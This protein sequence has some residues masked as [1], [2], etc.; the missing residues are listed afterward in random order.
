MPTK[1]L[2][3]PAAG[4][5]ERLSYQQQ[6]PF[7]TRKCLN[8][9]PEE[10]IGGRD[11]GG[12]RPGLA[13]DYTYT[14]FTGT[15]DGSAAKDNGTSTITP[16]ADVFDATVVGGTFT[17]D[18]SGTG[19]P[20]TAYNDVGPPAT[21][22]VTGDATVATGGETVDD[23][24]VVT[25]GGKPIAMG[26]GNP[27]NM[28]A[29]VR[30]VGSAGPGKLIQ[31]DFS[32]GAGATPDT[33]YWTSYDTSGWGTLYDGNLDV[34][35]ANNWLRNSDTDPDTGGH[36]GLV[37]VAS[38]GAG[39]FV[40]TSDINWA[41]PVQISFFVP[42][43]DATYG[44]LN[45]RIWKVHLFMDVTTPEQDADEVEVA[46]LC[47]PTSASNVGGRTRLDLRVQKT[48]GGAVTTL[49]EIQTASISEGHEPT[50][51]VK[52]RRAG[53][54]SSG[55][56]TFTIAVAVD[57]QNR[58]TTT[59]HAI[60]VSTY[61]RIGVSMQEN[62]QDTEVFPVPLMRDFS[63]QYSSRAH[64]VLPPEVIVAAAN[65]TVYRESLNLGNVDPIVNDNANGIEYDQTISTRQRLGKLYIADYDLIT[66]QTG[67]G[68]PVTID[69]DTGI[70]THANITTLYPT[71]GYTTLGV[72][73]VDRLE[74]T[75]ADNANAI[76]VW[77]ITSKTD[78]TITLTD[79][80]DL[81]D[82]DDEIASVKYRILCGPKVYDPSTD[83]LSAWHN[84]TN[85]V[86][87]AG[88][89]LELTGH[90]IPI[91]AKIVTSYKD[92]MILA[93]DGT[94]AVYMSRA[95]DPDDWDF[96]VSD[97]DEDRA[98]GLGAATSEIAGLPE[99]VTAVI[100]HGDDY[101]LISSKNTFWVLRGD[102]GSGGVLDNLS[103]D[104]GC[105]SRF[106]HCKDPQG[107]AFF[108]TNNGIY[109]QPPGATVYP[110]KLSKVAIPQ[111]LLTVDLEVIEPFLVYS[112]RYDGVF[113]YLAPK[114]KRPM[115]AWFFDSE[116]AGFFPVQYPDQ[117]HHPRSVLSYKPA[118]LAFT[119]TLLGGKDGFIRSLGGITDD[120]TAIS[121]ECVIG[122]IRMGL[123]GGFV[124]ELRAVLAEGSGDVDWALST[125]D[126]AE[127][128][129]GNTPPA[130]GT[131]EAG[132][133]TIDRPKVVG[134]SAYLHM[135]SVNQWGMESVEMKADAAPGH[136]PL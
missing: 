85:T 130:S 5:I 13:K 114:D 35:E 93:A 133:N 30:K 56:A 115:E 113:I 9:L 1:T 61:H 127:Q 131:W 21:I 23:T 121:S 6:P 73:A 97:T 76:G 79:W 124:N 43:N 54:D 41:E 25:G 95:G 47:F 123:Q 18:D 122:P 46:F 90:T 16:T 135:S 111:S 31:D 129:M 65:G 119:K 134:R 80:I 104:V 63:L 96:S 4:L 101:L 58:L 125:G 19:Y 91:A 27:V 82:G 10:N 107:G 89:P 3:F 7:S 103:H 33:D 36:K 92:R 68:D 106:A 128:A 44:A 64:A 48:V 49:K 69:D 29:S 98:I 94:G 71:N 2:I 84:T 66:D 126:A 59:T 42:D 53:V 112:L 28:L 109:Y 87:D 62:D 132:H 67:T 50:F 110:Q 55:N 40:G 100:P 15:V 102:P 39:D 105:I 51:G 11:R 72:T 118:T 57:G 74:I 78:T 52:V 86:I 45:Y 12:S 81:G 70:L 77:K 83:T 34:D 8:V 24:F 108:L 117:D 37:M 60:D 116:T 32:S 22:T 99:A 20:I 88:P 17:F 136:L 75:N 120:G 14:T 26:S 38:G